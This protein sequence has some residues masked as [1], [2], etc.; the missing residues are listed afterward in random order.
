M[1]PEEP[2][3]CIEWARDKFEKIFVQKPKNLQK[4]IENVDFIPQ[5]PQEIKTLKN[6]LKWLDKKPKNF[7]DCVT[8]A[9]NKFQKYFNNDIKQLLYVYPPDSKTKEGQLFWT[10]PKRPPHSTSFDA[11]SPLHADFIVAVA[12]LFAHTWSVPVPEDVRTEEGKQKYAA[13]AD[14]VQVAEY[15]PNKEKAAEISKEVEES[16]DVEEPKAAGEE[17][18]N[19]GNVDVVDEEVVNKLLDDLEDKL[20]GVAADNL[21]VTPEEFEK[22]NDMNFHIDFI[23]AMANCR[24]AC[25]GIDQ[26]SWISTKMKAGRIV[27]ALATTTAV[28]AGLQTLELV[29]LVKNLDIEAHR[30][31]FVNLALPYISLSQ[32]GAPK[33]TKLTEELKVTLWDRWEVKPPQGTSATLG[34]VMELLKS[35]YKLE[36]IDIFKGSKP[37]FLKSTMNTAGKAEEK[38]SLLKSQVK[39]ALNVGVSQGYV[40]LTVTFSRIGEEKLL[41]GVPTVRLLFK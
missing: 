6:A 22:D 25:Y 23:Y 2:V 39:D 35:T 37:I 29:K 14:K 13:M 12:S 4:F 31:A 40:D 18:K 11:K 5:S 33:E 26:I 32:P 38:E 30:N 36:P 27:P 3:H 17:A 15:T 10:L 24:S 16:K 34:E 21:F 7:N 19:E 28:V 9:R 1:F 8:F 41:A 20:A